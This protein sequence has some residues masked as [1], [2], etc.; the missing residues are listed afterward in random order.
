VLCTQLIIDRSS[1]TLYINFVRCTR[2]WKNPEYENYLDQPSVKTQLTISRA[3]YNY[4]IIH[5]SIR[6]YEIISISLGPANPY[7]G[8]HTKLLIRTYYFDGYQ[9]DYRDRRSACFFTRR[10][11][12]LKQSSEDVRLCVW[13]L[14]PSRRFPRPSFV[15]VRYRRLDYRGSYAS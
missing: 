9:F 4:P 8:F 11:Y 3:A 6:T 7:N 10:R 13:L 5:V 15:I 1:T 14:L 2:F 12:N